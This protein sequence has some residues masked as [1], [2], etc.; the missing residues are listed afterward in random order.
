M[1][2][3]G[4]T[5][6]PE[7][8]APQPAATV[9]DSATYSYR[10]VTTN[11][12]LIALTFDDGPA[13]AT[14]PKLL[15]ILREKNVKATFFMIGKNVAAHP[16]IAKEVADDGHEIAS[17]SWSHPHLSKMT[18]AAVTAELQKTEDALL[19]ATG[20]TPRY[21]RPPYGD[22]SNAQRQWVHE[23]FGYEFIFWSVDPEDWRKPGVS[24][25]VSRVVSA[26]GSGSIIL[27]HDIHA[28]SVSAVPAIIDQLRAKGY[29]FVTVSALLS[30]AR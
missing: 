13:A 3:C 5:K 26:T 15:E 11:E 12:P 9:G 7:P 28:D 25:V 23:K 22:F 27:L 20:R 24:A 10:R 19:A 2:S 8:V 6:S 16:L 14:T 21:L 1:I 4:T 30:A 29:K 17:H 18:E